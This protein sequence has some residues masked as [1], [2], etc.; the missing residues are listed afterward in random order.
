MERGYRGHIVTLIHYNLHK[1][2]DKQDLTWLKQRLNLVKRRI[3]YK[4]KFEGADGFLDMNF[5]CRIE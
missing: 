5:A 3:D 2:E 1:A 4:T